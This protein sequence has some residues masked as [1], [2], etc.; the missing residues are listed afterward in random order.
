LAGNEKTADGLFHKINH[1]LT[2]DRFS[3]DL[4]SS[5]KFSLAHGTKDDVNRARELLQASGAEHLAVH[6]VQEAVAAD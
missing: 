1:V 5:S 2:Q 3:H 4:V 6:H